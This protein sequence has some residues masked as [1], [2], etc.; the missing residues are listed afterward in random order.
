MNKL[1]N[2][3]GFTLVELLIA[4]LIVSVGMVAYAMTSGNIIKQNA[5]SKKKSVAVTL[6]QDRME[7]IRNTA[8]TI[9]LT[10]ADT[11]ASPTESGGVWTAN[12][13]GE[14]VDA[15]GDTG[16]ADA[17]YTRI[18]TIAEDATLTAFYTV[19]VTVTWDGSKTVVLDT[20][21]SQ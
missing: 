1:K 5:Q 4:A 17:I 9:S 16:T 13:S 11:L 15:K 8:L 18:W 12:A 10:G 21:V 6:A 20:L 7:S 3:S 19:A 2:E 14:V